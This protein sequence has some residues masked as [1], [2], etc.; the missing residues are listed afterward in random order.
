M[1]QFDVLAASLARRDAFKL[2]HY[3]I[4]RTLAHLANLR[5]ELVV[6]K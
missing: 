2:R 5:D 1:V 6:A 3:P 4:G